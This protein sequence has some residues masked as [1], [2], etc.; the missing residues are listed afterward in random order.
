MTKNNFISTL[1]MMGYK[2]TPNKMIFE[3]ENEYKKI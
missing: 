3:S 2:T 1:L